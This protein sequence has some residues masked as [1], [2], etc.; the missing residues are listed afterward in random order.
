MKTLVV[1]KVVLTGPNKKVLLLRRSETDVRRP[2]EF[3]LPGGHTDGTEYGNEAAARETLEEAGIQI[4]PRQLKLVYSEA[5][6]FADKDQSVIWLFFVGNTGS[7]EVNLSGEHSDAKW[8]TLDEAVE[9]VD[10]DRQKRA[11]KYVQDNDLMS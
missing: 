9:L 8:V 10:Y 7:T 6:S 11:L 5:K 4:D 3:D 2:G 1:A